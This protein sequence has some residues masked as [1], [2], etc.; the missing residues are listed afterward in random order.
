MEEVILAFEGE[1]TGAHIREILEGTGMVN[2]LLCH[3]GAEVKRLVDVQGITTVIC[4]YKLRDV[5][6]ESLF[7]DLPAGSSMLVIGKKA[8][9]DLM[10][11]EEIFKLAAPVSPGDLLTA[12]RLLLRMERRSRRS[13]RPARSEEEKVQI[14][15]AKEILMARYGMSEGQAHRFLQKRSMDSGVKMFQTAQMVLEENGLF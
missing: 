9:L 14:E 3:S 6:A 2:C 11:N 4:G 1:K 12:V 13:V 5:D 10:G 7:V 15:K 8:M